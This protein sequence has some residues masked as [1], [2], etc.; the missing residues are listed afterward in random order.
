SRTMPNGYQSLIDNC[1]EENHYD[2]ALDLLES[3][4]SQHYHP[5]EQHIRRL[6]DII[7]SDQVDDYIASR[8]Y[9]VLQH[10]L[11]TSGN[12]A[13]QYIWTSEQIDTEEGTLWANY[14][15]FWKF[16]EKQFTSL[17]K[18]NKDK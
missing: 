17:T 14:V 10:I 2:A 5:P 8:A 7:A 12:A 16:I 6:M 3:C 11:Q 18:V 9:K 15:N 4:Q 1:L 13:F